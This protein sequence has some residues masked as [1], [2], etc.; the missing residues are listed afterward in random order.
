MT[1]ILQDVKYALRTFRSS[2]GLV[3]AVVVTL[4]VAV[5]GNATLFSWIEGVV[6]RPMAGVPEQDRVVAIAGIRQPGDRC[7]VFSYPDYVDYRDQ[8]SVLE[9]IVAGELIGPTSSGDGKA[10]RVIGQIVTG[11]YFDVLRVEAQL[12]RTFLPDEDRFPMASPVVVISDGFWR[13]RFGA[14]PT[15]VG[16]TI[17]LNRFP[18][19][20]VGVAPP[21]FIGTFVG[22]SLDLWTPTAMEQVFFPGGDHRSDRG[23][24]WL[25]GYARLKAGVT[26]DQAQA[27]LDVISRRLQTEFPDTHRGFLLEAFPLWKTPY[28]GLPLVAPVL[29]ISA[30]VV[31]LVLL[32]AA[33]NIAGLL[34]TRALHR[35]PEMAIR[36]SLGATRW[37]LG[38]QILTESCVYGLAGG[39]LGLC[40]P[41]Y[42]QNTLPFFFPSAGVRITMDGHLDGRVLA[43]TFLV[44]VITGMCFGL[45]PAVRGMSTDTIDA[46]KDNSLTMSG[47]G[48]GGRIRAVFLVTQIALTIVLLV[49]AGLFLRTLWNAGRADLGVDRDHTLIASFDLF[50]GGYDDARGRALLRRLIG[51]TRQLPGVVTASV[52]MRLPFSVRGSVTAPIEVPGYLHGPDDVPYAEYNL[53]GPDYARAIGLA[54]LRGR[55]LSDQDQQQSS[56][57]AIVNDTMARR[58]WA[59]GDAV[60]KSFSILGKSVQIVGVAKDAYYHSLTEAPRPYVYLPV[61]QAYQGQVTLIVR[62]AGDPTSVLQPVQTAVA[63]IDSQ[64]PLY[65]VLPMDVYLGFAVVGQRTAGVLL[66]IFGALALLL[67]SLGLYNAVSYSI[68]IRSREV[69]IRLALGGRPADVLALL[70]RSG[71]AVTG[72]GIAIGL[73]G[74]AILARLI[75]S[76]TFGVSTTDPATY[77][78]ATLVVAAT[79]F[80]AI[81][82]PARRVSYADVTS[83][84]KRP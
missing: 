61:Q 43:L 52:A 15:V 35:R 3:A 53:V 24:P 45:W 64:L 28:G 31:A 80:L 71:A 13:R 37:R 82:I 75:A 19:T 2:R 23:H 84:L 12:G 47:S 58:Y 66:A 68:A 4:G 59:D 38:R 72:A 51:E 20:I 70:T 16:R 79:A 65:T 10:E 77:A 60:G 17:L 67:A 54:M 33:A 81:G 42:L 14:D 74:A 50:Q 29:T 49:G 40:L 69:A 6:L 62:A 22:Y 8:N 57:V 46:I 7:C 44:A 21:R 56:P 25:E 32:I 83:T 27:A 11:N 78:A 30:V 63:H 55:D 76:Q 5:G 48:R 26:R 34:L 1:E 39:A 9:G 18:F 41:W 73:V 36:L